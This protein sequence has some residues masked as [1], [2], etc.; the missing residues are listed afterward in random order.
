MLLGCGKVKG[1]VD[2]EAARS[3]QVLRAL[4]AR[5]MLAYA[6]ETSAFTA[7]DAMTGVGLTRTTVIDVCDALV[8]D[9]WLE[10][11]SDARAAG[12]YA[13]GR[14]ARR[15]AL[16]DRAGIVVGLDAGF[17]RMSAVAADLRGRVV[18][19]SSMRIPARFPPLG[20]GA[21]D[22]EDR[23]ALAR[24]LVDDVIARS[25]ATDREVLAVSIAVPAPVDPAG[26]SPED[27]TGFWR[28]M[29]P[30]LAEAV[31]GVAPIVAIEN[32][33][34][35]AAIAEQ[36]ALTG[37][38]HDVDSFI[39]LLV[40]EG[41]GAGLMVDRRLIRGRRG[42]AGE[43]RFL[44]HVEGVRSADG[45]ALLARQWAAEAVAAGEGGA[46]AHHES[47]DEN[48]VATAAHA[49]D[50]VATRIVD[51][52]ADRLAR[53][54]LVLGDL[55]DVD[56]IVVGGAVAET[57]P[58]VIDRAAVILASSDDPTVP[59]LLASSLKQDAVRIGAVEHALALVRENALD[60]RGGVVRVA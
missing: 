3:P 10:E 11:L 32:D 50:A 40:G 6:W 41:I 39:A 4:N 27:E 31:A 15:Y 17:D 29:N 44:D 59:Q 51:R 28:I 36:A 48:D 49:G 5:R 42:G 1:L 26:F 21:A 38:G 22:A 18:A 43:M 7:S 13:K 45:L 56:R 46:L 54:C 12:D 8:R 53:I 23:R 14:P 60:L 25:G 16:R 47:P 33:A 30:R 52:L 9:G 58:D 37:L 2:N 24:R 34:N 57:L 35:L 55:L 19:E 20:D